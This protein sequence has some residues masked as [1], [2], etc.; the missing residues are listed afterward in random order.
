M[1]PPLGDGLT[2]RRVSGFTPKVLFLC[3]LS[4]GGCQCVHVSLYPSMAFISLLSPA[5]LDSSA[6]TKS[7][8]GILGVSHMFFFKN[9]DKGRHRGGKRKVD[10]ILNLLNT[11]DSPETRLKM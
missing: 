8:S 3:P 5:L 4:V 11:G 7:H 10:F 1:D 6:P 2:V 9:N